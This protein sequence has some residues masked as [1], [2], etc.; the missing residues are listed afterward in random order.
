MLVPHRPRWS[1]TAFFSARYS[2]M[3]ER[4]LENNQDRHNYLL[5]GIQKQNKPL[6]SEAVWFWF[7]NKRRKMMDGCTCEVVRRRAE[8]QVCNV[9]KM[10]S[11]SSLT[12]LWTNRGQRGCC[13]RTLFCICS[14][15][16]CQTGETEAATCIN[17]V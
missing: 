6:C 13:S 1:T 12:H 3:Q 9:M 17:Q 8:P 16:E 4:R 2:T 14:Q 5:T 15:V 7:V 10:G 11:S